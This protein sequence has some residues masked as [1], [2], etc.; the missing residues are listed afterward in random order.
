MQRPCCV[1]RFGV[2]NVLSFCKGA[3]AV[4]GLVFKY[5]DI[6]TGIQEQS[7]VRTHVTIFTSHTIIREQYRRRYRFGR[8]VR[9]LERVVEIFAPKFLAVPFPYFYEWAVVNRHLRRIH[10]G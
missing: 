8:L 5:S 9:Q 3:L 4:H 7:L 6:G 1:H 2:H 10:I